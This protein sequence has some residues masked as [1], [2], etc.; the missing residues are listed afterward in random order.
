VVKIARFVRRCGAWTALGALAALAIPGCVDTA[1]EDAVG[2]LG[3][4]DPGV[5]PGGSHRPG[6]PCITC[7]GGSGPA[8]TQFSVAGT[9]YAVQGRSA[10]AQN[11]LVIVEDV[12]GN[13]FTTTTNAAGNFWLLPAQ[14]APHYPTQMTVSSADGSESQSMATVASR[15]GSCA[16]CHQ[17]V[18]GPSSPGPVFLA[19]APADGGTP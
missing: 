19:T 7:H 18:R 14:F 5:P 8:S 3:P 11:A 9:V 17:K 2:A 10:P 12:D 13:A 15:D 4:E 16:D 1:H 6:Q